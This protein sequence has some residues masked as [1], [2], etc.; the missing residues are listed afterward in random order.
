MAEY[1]FDGGGELG[2]LPQNSVSF[3]DALRSHDWSQTPLGPIETWSED[4]K[5]GSAACTN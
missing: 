1:L 4:L 3:K 2:A 5:T